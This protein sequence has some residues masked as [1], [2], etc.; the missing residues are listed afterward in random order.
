MYPHSPGTHKKDTG[1]YQCCAKK[2]NCHEIDLK[3]YTPLLQQEINIVSKLDHPFIARSYGSYEH[4][5]QLYTIFEYCSGQE[6]LTRSFTEEAAKPVIYQ[7]LLALS[8]L[9]KN[10]IVHRDI[11]PQNVLFET[12]SPSS[13]VKLIDFGMAYKHDLGSGNFKKDVY[14]ENLYFISFLLFIF[15][16]YFRIHG[17][18][19][20]RH[21]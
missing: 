1:L 21:I 7:I 5:M 12:E 17:I 13:P 20:R 14:P 4:D 10:R 19:R 18:N 2:I 8:Y 6:L 15:L 16:I 9:C 3:L 11:N